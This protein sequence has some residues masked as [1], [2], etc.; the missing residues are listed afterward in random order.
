MTEDD[1]CY[2]LLIVDDEEDV[3]FMFRQQ[4]RRDVRRGRYDLVFA[5]NGREALDLLIRDGDVDLVVTD[6]NMPVMN[7]L[8][9]LDRMGELVP[10]TPVLVLSA[11]GD[12]R[13]V[14]AAM[15]RGAYDFVLKPVDFE[16]LRVTLDRAVSKMEDAREAAESRERLGTLEK[17]LDLASTM[18]SRILPTTFPEDETLEV[19]ARMKAARNVGG[20]FYDVMQLSDTKVG[21]VIAD[22]S[23]KGVPAALMMMASRT[24]IKGTAAAVWEPGAVL[25]M[26]N[27]LL[28]QE[29]SMT[30]FV[31]VFYGVYDMETGVMEYCN[32]G[33]CPP[34][35][36]DGKGVSRELP[37]TGGVVLGLAP[38][39]VYRTGTVSVSP[40]ELVFMFT[41]GVIESIDVD[42]EEFGI[43]RLQ[44]LFELGVLGRARGVV[45]AVF[46]AVER[47]SAGRERFD[48]ITCLV[49]RRK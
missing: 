29:N 47:F 31:T 26:V 9:L 13:N 23:G 8:E 10:D 15:N 39:V 17:E 48:D 6:V 43:E 42:G 21:L 35:L 19:Y 38:G 45:N 16:D 25:A 30:M 22:V 4:M 33:H 36:V 44:V 34:L 14:R 7:G 20:D 24:L 1:K 49:L 12:M 46:D 5:V 11:Y 3:E 41:D 40:G 37:L 18:Q 28:Y 27:D 32:G 2:R